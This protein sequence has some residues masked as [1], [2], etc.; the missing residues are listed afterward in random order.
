[1]LKGFDY[2]TDRMARSMQDA[3]RNLWKEKGILCAWSPECRKVFDSWCADT[4]LW[5]LQNDV[6]LEIDDGRKGYIKVD[7]L[8]E[9]AD[10]VEG[11]PSQEFSRKVAA[12]FGAACA[13]EM[14]PLYPYRS[15]ESVEHVFHGMS[16]DP[17]PDFAWH[18]LLSYPAGMGGMPQLRVVRLFNS[19][20]ARE[21]I[22]DDIPDSEQTIIPISTQAIR[23]FKIQESFESVLADT[24]RTGKSNSTMHEMGSAFALAAKTAERYYNEEGRDGMNALQTSILSHLGVTSMFDKYAKKTVFHDR[25][26]LASASNY[27]GLPREAFIRIMKS[28]AS[29]CFWLGRSNAM[30][31]SFYQKIRFTPNYNI[32]PVFAPKRQ[33]EY[34]VS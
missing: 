20:N 28:A 31:K 29:Y 18:E 30:E 22:A 9:I 23:K 13:H 10:K 14:D 3:T 12:D 19:T 26:I 5:C 1:M 27:T 2:L 15:P 32:T 24:F 4:L 11:R 6:E 25:I 16:L 17:N 33:R 21:C 7:D 8:M 34:E